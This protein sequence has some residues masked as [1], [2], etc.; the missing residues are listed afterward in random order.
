MVSTL[1][2]DEA[3]VEVHISNIHKREA[4]RHHSY[5]S[6]RAD[7]VIVGCGTEGYLLALRRVV[8]LVAGLFLENVAARVEAEDYP[9]DPPGRVWTRG[10]RSANRCGCRR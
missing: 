10:G 3:E 2:M 8:S 6:G 5:I 7:G 4:F 1:I 9:A